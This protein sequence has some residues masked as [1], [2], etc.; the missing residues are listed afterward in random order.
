MKAKVKF[1]SAQLKGFLLHHGEKLIFGGFVVAFLLISWS[2]FKLKP[3][4]KTPA[5]LK[6][7][8]D[9]M[10]QKVEGKTPPE[11]FT[12]LPNVPNF[13]K[14]LGAGGPAQVNP[15][16]YE[17]KALNLPYEE[18]QERRREPKFFA[19]EEPLAFPG[20]GGIAIGEEGRVT[21][22]ATTFGSGMTNDAGS[23]M[24]GSYGMDMMGAQAGLEEMQRQ[25]Q[26]QQ[27]AAMST[28][29][30][31]SMMGSYGNMGAGARGGRR[32]ARRPAK[33]ATV[34]PQQPKPIARPKPQTTEKIVISSTPPNA[35]VEGRYWV[36]LVGAVP[37]WKQLN[38]YQTTFRDARY[39]DV[40]Q[41]YPRYAFPIIERAEVDGSQVGE[42]EELNVDL[43][44]DDLLKWAAEYPEVADKQILDPYLTE[45]LPPLVFANHDKEKVSHPALKP[46][47]PKKVDPEE[48]KKKVRVRDLTG[49][50]ARNRNSGNPGMSGAAPGMGPGYGGQGAYGGY[51][52]QMNG[53]QGP[54]VERRLFRFFDFTVDPGKTY[55]YRVKLV[56]RNP[57]LGVPPRFLDN[58]DFA[59]GE[60]RESDWS[61]PSPAVT[62][63]AGNRLLAGG[64]TPGRN[65][66]TAKILAK[67]FDA[68]LA[69]EIRRIF[70]I[71]RGSVL[72]ELG[73]KIGLP[74]GSGQPNDREAASLDFE[75]NAVVLDMFGGDKIPGAR[76]RDPRAEQ[77]RIPGHI[78]VLDNDGDLRTLVQSTDAG[79]YETEAEEAR[80]QAPPGEGDKKPGG[81]NSPPADG[82]FNFDAIDDGKKP[83]GRR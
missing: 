72:N 47:E 41:D 76:S 68:K 19:L 49:T 73:A 80:N 54:L 5:D 83:K 24:S 75:T 62:V 79:M 56:L 28:Q 1:D 30:Q 42:W 35:K 4:E 61:P 55:R 38:E 59:K 13:T 20:Y 34:K 58:Y 45:P 70:D 43:A 11:Q 23:G 17:V 36:C 15:A 12:D 82:F 52:N 9:D 51:G 64:V 74:K 71:S 25:Q 29:N 53:P 65:E 69:A 33:N 44:M 6:K 2:A 8:A 48:G 3:Y 37:Y 67:L 57:N 18:R 32:N 60:T 10:S 66:P 39:Y 31:S 27:Q 16:F 14:N 40:K 21:R 7:L 63:I 22:V 77:P 50:T 26:Q 46:T 81:A 78:L